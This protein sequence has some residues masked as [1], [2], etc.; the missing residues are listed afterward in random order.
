MTSSNKILAI[1]G[2]QSYGSK[3][4]RSLIS[5][6]GSRV[7]FLGHINNREHIQELYS[8]CWA[9]IHGASLGGIN[10]ALLRPLGCGACVLALD[11]LFNQEV[12]RMNDGRMC[13]I[14]W[15]RNIEDLRKKIVEIDPN[16]HLAES[17]RSLAQERIREAFTWDRIALQY[18]ALYTGIVNGLPNTEIRKLV[19]EL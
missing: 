12:L 14:I 5:N 3:W 8:N 4:A 2:G 10:S 9:Y 13:G 1:A 7:K 16:P 19:A 17:L 18:E 6:S 15:K 11:T